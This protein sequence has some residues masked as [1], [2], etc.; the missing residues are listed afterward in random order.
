MIKLLKRNY[1]RQIIAKR[2]VIE[3]F[4]LPA[5]ARC[6]L[7]DGIPVAAK[8]LSNLLSS[9]KL[10]YL[11]MGTQSHI[12]TSIASRDT[13]TIRPWAVPSIPV[14]QASCDRGTNACDWVGLFRRWRYTRPRGRP[15]TRRY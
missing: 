12:S 5:R 13:R 15:P 6:A 1:C 3:P 14:A 2:H 8:A 9:I 4:E 7:W 11:S 10:N